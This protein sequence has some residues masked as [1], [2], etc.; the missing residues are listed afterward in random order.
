MKKTGWIY[1]LEYGIVC[2]VFVKTR[3]LGAFFNIWENRS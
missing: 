1:A 3:I 2:P